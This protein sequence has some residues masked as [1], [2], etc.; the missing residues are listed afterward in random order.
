MT[1]DKLGVDGCD[2]QITYVL[3]ND[4]PTPLRRATATNSTNPRVSDLHA[5]SIIE[6]VPESIPFCNVNTVITDWALEA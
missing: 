6:C 5:G 1:R 2:D 3:S 4:V